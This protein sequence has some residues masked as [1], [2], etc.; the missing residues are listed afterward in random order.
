MRAEAGKEAAEE[1]YG[2]LVLALWEYALRPLE[3]PH[4]LPSPLRKSVVDRGCSES[5]QHASRLLHAHS[6]MPPLSRDGWGMVLLGAVVLCA[7]VAIGAN[8]ERSVRRH[9]VPPD[10]GALIADKPQV[11]QFFFLLIA[12]HEF[13]EE[14]G[15]CSWWSI[16][17][18]RSGLRT[19]FASA[20]HNCFRWTT[21]RSGTEFRA[22]TEVL[23]SFTQKDSKGY[24]SR[25]VRA[26]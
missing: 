23:G 10:G 1:N 19:G 13:H 8:T 14:A 26:A 22:A 6:R 2:G 5:V 7:G 12:T 4:V 11:P 16:V 25:A 20:A 3:D 15:A 17:R 21:L 24:D 9:D 18:D